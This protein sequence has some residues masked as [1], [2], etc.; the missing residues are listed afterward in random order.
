[1]NYLILKAKLRPSVL[2][3]LN[4]FYFFGVVA[5]GLLITQPSQAFTIDFRNPAVIDENGIR[6]INTDLELN[7]N[8]LDGAGQSIDLDLTDSVGAQL[9]STSVNTQED[10]NGNIGRLLAPLGLNITETNGGTIGLFNSECIPLGGS[11]PTAEPDNVAC[12]VSGSLGDPDLATGEVTFNEGETDE[13]T[14]STVPRGNLLIVEENVGDGTPDDAVG[15]NILVSFDQTILDQVRLQS[16]LIVDDAHGSIIVDF[17]DPSLD[18]EIIL[19]NFSAGQQTINGTTLQSLTTTGSILNQ[20]EFNQ[21][22]SDPENIVGEI[23]GFTQ[24]DILSFE[25]DFVSSGGF[26]AFTFNE[27]AGDNVEVVPFGFSPT[28]GLVL[29]GGLFVGLRKRR[30]K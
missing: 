30:Q 25:I 7:P 3:L 5:S 6:R 13:R 14:I 29:S 1:M 23:G 4:N 21:F 2:S 19:F 10:P 11:N 27:F 22:T 26:G 24:E 12:N 28:L 20:S 18:N 15:G 8:L 16:V 17:V 9:F